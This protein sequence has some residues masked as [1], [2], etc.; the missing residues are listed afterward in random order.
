[1]AGLEVFSE[2]EWSVRSV[3]VDGE[4]WFV[5]KDVT[6]ILGLANSRDAVS[7]LPERMRGVGNADTPGGQQQVALISEA[8]VYRLVMRSSKAEAEAFQDWLAEDVVPQIRRTGTYQPQELTRLQL[9]ELALDSEKERIA[10]VEARDAARRQ[11]AVAAPKV[12]A[13]EAFMDSEG[14]LP[15]GAAAQILGYGRTTFFKELR[16]LGIL[17][18]DNRPYQRHLKHFDV[19]AGSYT[20]SHGR[21]HPTYTTRV[22]P[23]GVE[24][25]RRRLNAGLVGVG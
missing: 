23:D 8:G 12:E 7:R 20:D 15:M 24:F 18:A 3:L 13:Y 22:R 25:I 16:R 4:P 19:I 6:G 5:A 11:L 2:G 1:M 21:A 14:L 10:A 9:I 17:Q